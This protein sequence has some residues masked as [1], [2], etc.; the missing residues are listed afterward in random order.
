MSLPL[1]TISSIRNKRHAIPP[2]T[3]PAAATDE[4]IPPQ[5]ASRHPTPLFDKPAELVVGKRGRKPTKRIEQHDSDVKKSKEKAGLKLKTKRAN[6]KARKKKEKSSKGNKGKK[7]SKQTAPEPEP[8][9]EPEDGEGAESEQGES[10]DGSSG[11]SEAE[12]EAES[13]E[14]GTQESDVGEQDAVEG[15]EV[16]AAQALADSIFADYQIEDD[17]S[18]L[19]PI[20]SK[21][22]NLLGPSMNV[23]LPQTALGKRPAEPTPPQRTKAQ[24]IAQVPSTS[25][26]PSVPDRNYVTPASFSPNVFAQNQ[27]NLCAVPLQASVAPVPVQTKKPKKPKA[28]IGR[29][30]EPGEDTDI[31]TAA[32]TD[33]KAYMIAAEP[34][35]VGQVR[36]DM[37]MESWQR[38]NE[39]L[40]P[41]L[42]LWPYSQKKKSIICQRAAQFRSSIRDK[43]K[44]LVQSTFG[45]EYPDTQAHI[46]ANSY[47]VSCLLEKSAFLCGTYNMP[48]MPHLWPVESPDP[49]DPSW[50]RKFYYETGVLQQIINATLFRDQDDLGVVFGAWFTPFP[51]P[52]LALIITIL[53]HCIKEWS[54]GVEVKTRLNADQDLSRYY[55]HLENLAQYEKKWP[56]RCEQ[57]MERFTRRGRIHAKVPEDLAPTGPGAL[58]PDDFNQGMDEDEPLRD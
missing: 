1:P 29:D 30:C 5:P 22:P 32:F 51:F 28:S 26:T 36:D 35:P 38:A 46:R 55:V 3:P 50:E 56:K 54:T 40:R 33:Y 49:N 2:T 42:P 37:A 39:R 18:D 25:S 41:G 8:E 58:S 31:T 10:E 9:P 53:E 47:L 34:F 21:A 15:E 14:D 57:I 43:I 23:N 11:E 16:S 27:F 44:L 52:A 20:P 13:E 7:K 12:S 17:F 24:R 19:S 48:D 6:E 45:I 4:N